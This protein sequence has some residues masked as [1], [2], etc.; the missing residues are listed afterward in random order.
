MEEHRKYPKDPED[1]EKE[2]PNLYSTTYSDK[3]LSCNRKTRTKITVDQLQRYISEGNNDPGNREEYNYMSRFLCSDRFDPSAD[4]ND[5]GLVD[6]KARGKLVGTVRVIGFANKDHG[7]NAYHV[8]EALSSWY[9]SKDTRIRKL[10]GSAER[11]KGGFWGAYV[12]EKYKEWDEYKHKSLFPAHSYIQ[13]I[14]SVFGVFTSID[15]SGGKFTHNDLRMENIKITRDNQI[16]ITNFRESFFSQG[17]GQRGIESTL[18]NKDRLYGGVSGYYPI[19]D[20]KTVLSE[21]YA[22]SRGDERK[23]I[24][25]LASNFAEDVDDF[26]SS[27]G[28][29]YVG[30][31]V[32]NGEI[33]T[34]LL[35]FIDTKL[36]EQDEVADLALTILSTPEDLE[37]L[38]DLPADETKDDGTEVVTIP[39]EIVEKYPVSLSQ[40]SVDKEVLSEYLS[41]AR[42]LFDRDIALSVVASEP[43]DVKDLEGIELADISMPESSLTLSKFI[44]NDGILNVLP[45]FKSGE[46]YYQA[47]PDDETKRLVDIEENEY[48][49]KDEIKIMIQIID[50]FVQLQNEG[51]EVGKFNP[52]NVSTLRVNKGKY[53]MELGKYTFD[54]DFAID[55]D[56]DKLV[57]FKALENTK[58]SYMMGKKEYVVNNVGPEKPGD[59]SVMGFLASLINNIEIAHFVTGFFVDTDAE[60]IETFSLFMSICITLAISYGLT[61]PTDSY[62]DDA[63]YTIIQRYLSYYPDE[64]SNMV[65]E[66]DPDD[67]DPEAV[68]LYESMFGD[69]DRSMSRIPGRES[70]V[71]EGDN[72]VVPNLLNEI[73]S[74]EEDYTS[75]D[76]SSTSEEETGDEDEG[77][78]MAFERSPRPGR[79]SAGSTRR[80]RIG[81]RSPGGVRSA[82]PTRPNA[83]PVQRPITNTPP[84]G[85]P[86]QTASPPPAGSP[87]QT[88]SSS[89]TRSPTRQT[90]NINKSVAL[91]E[92]EDDGDIF[93][94]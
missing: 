72:P 89:R 24:R 43:S 91:D 73:I 77:E 46:D 3:Y 10:I 84:T 75:E 41:N 52:Q 71:L 69:L 8:T 34:I 17:R 83:S 40:Y 9:D 65:Y 19:F 30:E 74:D 33:Y 15:A 36:R 56:V 63:P 79:A 68:E 59:V 11:E 76:E 47:Y 7:I 57:I 78:V 70:V 54:A 21:V 29:V 50:T 88:A 31:L 62:G 86:E 16:V 4:L 81:T 13:I 58:H 92:E 48:S 5:E 61:E 49:R 2:L 82:T 37:A 25:E 51:Y 55:I 22:I 94:F 1:H 32:T 6:I 35:A 20:I 67:D 87:E 80:R 45:L 39:E 90:V 44:A 26:L 27:K 18:E 93:S 28:I 38:R 23:V 64:K 53:Q 66:F 12:N 42:Y 14:T 85:S 60:Y